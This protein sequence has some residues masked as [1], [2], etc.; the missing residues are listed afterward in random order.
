MN[1]DKLDKTENKEVSLKETSMKYFSQ[2]A[3][4]KV[5]WKEIPVEFRRNIKEAIS[6]KT[7]ILSCQDQQDKRKLEFF[8]NRYSKILKNIQSLYK[9]KKGALS[10]FLSGVIAFLAEDEPEAR[11]IKAADKLLDRK[12]VV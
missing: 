11:N 6:N 1:V 7:Q 5:R 9:N 10:N 12:S 4:K 8:S 3:F 2:A